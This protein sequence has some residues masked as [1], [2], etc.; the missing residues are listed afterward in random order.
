VITTVSVTKQD[1]GQVVHLNVGDVLEVSL[2]EQEPTAAWKAE[3]DEEILGLISQSA[4]ESVW[5][6]GETEQRTVRQFRAKKEGHATLKMSYQRLGDTGISTL[7]TFTRD[8]TVGSPPAEAPK[9]QRVPLP[10]MVFVLTEIF[11]LAAAFVYVAFTLAV[12]AGQQQPEQSMPNV[13]V[14][15]TGTV[16]AGAVAIFCLLRV[17]SMI[18]NRATRRE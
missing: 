17:L 4:G 3:V 13:M 11:L 7:D 16:L 2:G 5:L 15:L 18:V 12:Y 10:E 14:G 8:V 6:L 1:S 9:R